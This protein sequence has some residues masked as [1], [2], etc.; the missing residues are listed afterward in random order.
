LLIPELGALETVMDTM[1]S[2]ADKDREVRDCDN[3]SKVC[4]EIKTVEIEYSAA[5]SYRHRKL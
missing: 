4:Q 5:Q 1:I 3:T 2:I